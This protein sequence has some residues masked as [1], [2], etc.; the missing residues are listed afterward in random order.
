M[1]NTPSSS[2][3]KNSIS[4][5]PV[6]SF[7]FSFSSLLLKLWKVFGGEEEEEDGGVVASDGAAGE[8][9]QDEDEDEGE[10]EAGKA[11]HVQV[12][13]EIP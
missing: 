4:R 9:E 10:G 3:S 8:E 1:M 6:S 11:S 7:I 5:G 12:P 2:T 13:Q